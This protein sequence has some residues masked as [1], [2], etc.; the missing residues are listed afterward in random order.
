MN[1]DINHHLLRADIRAISSQILALKRVLRAP[2]QQPMASEQR[3]LCKL[4]RR[5]T[6][7]YALRAFVRGKLH[8]Q[9][10]PLGAGHDW[11]AAE[12]HRRIAERLG[13]SYAIN[14]EESA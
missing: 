11:N 13:P 12:Y 1:F 8:L 2:W 6:E 7:L 3:E 4:K 10:A 9:R 14:L 5:A